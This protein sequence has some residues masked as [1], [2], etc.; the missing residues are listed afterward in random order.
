METLDRA[1]AL[2]ASLAAVR[3][4][5]GTGADP[6]GDALRAAHLARTLAETNRCLADVSERHARHVTLNSVM[7]RRAVRRL[8]LQAA[9]QAAEARRQESSAAQIRGLM[10]QARG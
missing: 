2:L 3:R 4:A 8:R 1:A 9:T 5:A 6:L 7:H 10:V